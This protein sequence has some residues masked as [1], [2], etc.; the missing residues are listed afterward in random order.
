MNPRIPALCLTLLVALS[1][2]EAS[3]ASPDA[4][5]TA[6]EA[7]LALSPDKI[8]ALPL[9]VNALAEN[10]CGTPYEQV[11]LAK[12]RLTVGSSGPV[13]TVRRP[14]E[15]SGLTVWQPTAFEMKGAPVVTSCG[16]WEVS[17]SL[18]TT[19]PQPLSPLVLEP[20]AGDS[21]HGFLASVLAVRAHLHLVNL[22]TGQ[23]FD[24]PLRLGLGLVGPWSLAS[25]DGTTDPA[26]S[27]LR[28]FP[29]GQC[30]PVWLLES[31]ALVGQ[32]W[33]GDCG[34]C[35]KAARSDHAGE[36]HP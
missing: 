3:A 24:D 29:D 2:A 32:F 30:G 8:S 11:G 20:A 13:V 27:S 16:V 10:R 36:I 19:A 25:P 31:S 33:Y 35:L 21:T 12:C 4:S 22:R 9:D 34:L 7:Q 15:P 17:L 18:D 23:T 28:V 14:D 5:P 1:A 26:T 6:G